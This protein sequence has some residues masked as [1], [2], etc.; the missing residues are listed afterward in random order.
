ML[1][2][3]EDIIFIKQLGPTLNCDMQQR[4]NWAVRYVE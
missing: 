2:V 1:N 4:Q 3:E